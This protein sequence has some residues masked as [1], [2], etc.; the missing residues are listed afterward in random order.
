MS[1]DAL[2]GCRLRRPVRRR[3]VHGDGLGTF[4]VVG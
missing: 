3:L 1:G 2:E 4:F